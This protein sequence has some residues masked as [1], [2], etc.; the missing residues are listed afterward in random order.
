MSENCLLLNVWTPAKGPH[1]KLPVMMW[2]HGGG[3]AGGFASTPA[4][5][6]W[7]QQR[8]S[9]S[10]PVY[11]YLYTHV[12]PG[13][14]AARF[15]VFHSSEIPYVIDTLDTAQR[16]FVAQD[17]QIAATLGSYWINFVKAGDPNGVGLVPWPDLR[18]GQLMELGEHFAPMSALTTEKLKV[19][20]S[21]VDAG[22]VLGLF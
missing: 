3:F 11:A 21:Y 5:I 6:Q 9:G 4:M 20:Q 13:P 8:P 12:E 15:G 22:G 17:R 2:I 14:Q 18:S 16:P 10:P 1:D 19:Y 7:A